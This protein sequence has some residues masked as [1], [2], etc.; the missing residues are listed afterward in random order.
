MAC[1][2]SLLF[3]PYPPQTL[4]YTMKAC[5]LFSCLFASVLGTSSLFAVSY[6]SMGVYKGGRGGSTPGT[7]DYLGIKNFETW[8]GH[9]IPRG[10]DF[11][12]F[13]SWSAFDDGA[14]FVAANIDYPKVSHGCWGNPTY[15]RWRCTYSTPL[16]VSGGTLAAAANG[17]YDSHF[18]TLAGYLAQTEPN[19]IVRLSWEMNG[20][21]YPW[22]VTNAVDAA[23]F[24]AAWRR[25]VATMRQIA[26][27]LR[28]DFCPALG[29][30][31]FP[32]AE[33]YPGDDYVDFIGLDV[34]NQTWITSPTPATR[35][36]DLVNSPYGVQFWT[37]FAAA[38]GKPLSFPE[39]GTGTRPDGHGGG[40][41]PVFI[42]NMFNWLV[43]HN[44]A[45]HNYWDYPADDYNAQLSNDQYPS[46][47]AL[48][49]TLFGQSYSLASAPLIAPAGGT[50]TTSQSVTLSTTTP[51]AS[52][53][54]TL[55]GTTP[56]S[57]SGTLYTA[58]VTIGTSATLKAIAYATGYT[59]STIT[60]TAYSIQYPSGSPTTPSGLNAV[61]GSVQSNSQIILFWNPSS[62]AP[63][64]YNIKRAPSGSGP[65][66]LI[67]TSTIP[68]FADTTAVPGTSYSYAVSAVNS[69]GESAI[70]S[71]VNATA[72]PSV[73]VDDAD[74]TGVTINGSWTVSSSTSGF[75]G[76]GYRL[77]GATAGGKSVIFTPT[78]PGGLTNVYLRWTAGTNRASNVPV[79]VV[80]SGGT[81]NFTVNQQISGGQWV[82]LPGGPFNFNAGSSGYV[83]I[84]DN[85]G[86]PGLYVVA[87]A[88]RFVS[89]P[90]AATVNAPASLTA[91]SAA[92]RAVSLSWAAVSGATR[93]IV[94]R[95]WTG[96]GSFT[97]LGTTTGTTWTDQ[98]LTNGTN[99]DYVVSAIGPGG[100]SGNSPVLTVAPVGLIVMVTN[101][102][103][104]RPYVASAPA[105]GNFAAIDRTYTISALSA[106]LADSRNQ[107]ILTAYDDKA[108]TSSSHLTFTLNRA[109]TVYVCYDG[110]VTTLPAFLNDGTW[111]LTTET[112]STTHTT[113][114]PFKVYSKSFAAGSVTLGGPLQ[115]PA[116]G[117]WPGGQNAPYF[118]I[119]R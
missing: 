38:H 106:N 74:T 5:A 71:S 78:L 99:Y 13:G 27:G 18:S 51:G 110:R 79:S 34:Y 4:V 12:D 25:I 115:S 98:G 116:A 32:A 54:Y 84:D 104:G 10:L 42:Q 40:D 44:V 80:H 14:I 70:S 58:P 39:W 16:V 101:V 67:G 119:V 3:A 48:F 49:K 102:S 43:T 69:L 87:D 20:Y 46:S 23:N 56:T 81:S 72:M 113:A 75:Y 97:L 50:Y 62:G 47:G 93:Y 60:T 21:W 31:K 7:A 33:A 90:P 86:A 85:T 55:D 22:A 9:T 57:M 107:M 35:W 108:V 82:L 83:K 65:F 109:A 66:N 92:D 19:A 15:S 111:T 100:E 73:I 29:L 88:V 77:D 1:G 89:P 68:C 45:Y 30:Q 36:N 94:K 112:F 17:D 103:S 37:D 61:V 59:S 28:F 52:I 95:A 114:S 6:P 118:V 26:P 41:D 96:G 11:V 8:F 91:T 64:S 63:T 76:S 105:V 2:A 53:R 117:T 24:I